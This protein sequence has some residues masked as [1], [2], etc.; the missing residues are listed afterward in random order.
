LK[1]DF[2]EIGQARDKMLQIKL[3]QAGTATS[4][5]SSSSSGGNGGGGGGGAG[6]GALGG[7]AST[8]D[9]KGYL[10]GLDS[11]MLKTSSEIGYVVAFLFPFS[12][13]ARLILVASQGHQ[14][15]E[16]SSSIPHQDESKACSRVGRSGLVGECCGKT[17]CSEKD[18]RSRLRSMSKERGCLDLR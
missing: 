16:S 13:F 15:S 5:G 7:L 2:A 17:S 10:T 11:Q 3:E 14:T 18:Y 6:A 12:S 9:P 1:Q 8:V 4:L